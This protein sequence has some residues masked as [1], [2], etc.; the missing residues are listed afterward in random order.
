MGIGKNQPFHTDIRNDEHAFYT[1]DTSEGDVY[2]AA[3]F[4]AQYESTHRFP[5]PLDRSSSFEQRIQQHQAITT[6]Q[7]KTGKSEGA[8][9]KNNKRNSLPKVQLKRQLE[10]VLYIVTEA[11]APYGKLASTSHSHPVMIQPSRRSQQI[12]INSVWVE[13]LIHD[14]QNIA[15]LQGA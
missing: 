5:S 7:S 10:D 11:R 13:M 3:Q 6:H 9:I 2:E 15:A 14:Q 1:D 8:K 4:M 12:D